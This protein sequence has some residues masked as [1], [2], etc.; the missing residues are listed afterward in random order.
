MN[1]DILLNLL[2]ADVLLNWLGADVLLMVRSQNVWNIDIGGRPVW[3]KIMIMMMMMNVWFGLKRTSVLYTLLLSSGWLLKGCRRVR[4]AIYAYT[5]LPVLY[6]SLWF[7]VFCFTIYI[8][9]ACPLDIH[10]VF[11][12]Y[13]GAIRGGA[14]GCLASP[15]LKLALLK[16]FR[17]YGKHCML[18][19]LDT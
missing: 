14:W 16:Y 19:K 4:M 1:A 3:E 10:S 18:I 13:M 5:E 7:F 11:L 12:L 17:I 6:N 2:E 15:V 8:I 9:W